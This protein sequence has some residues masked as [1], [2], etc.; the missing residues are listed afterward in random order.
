MTRPVEIL[1]LH[2]L[3]VLSLSAQE[4][5]LVMDS[6]EQRTIH[7]LA[8]Q[9]VE[10][11]LL[12]ALEQQRKAGYLEASLTLRPTTG[13]TLQVF[14]EQG[15][16]I[17]LSQVH[18]PR[19]TPRFE[20]YYRSELLLGQADIAFQDLMP[21]EQSLRDLGLTRLTS[22]EISRDAGG[23]YHL[24]YPESPQPELRIDAMAA[25]NQA[26]NTDTVAWYGNINLIVPNLGGSGKRIEL[27][28]KR[29]RSNSERFELYYRHPLLFARP[30]AAEIR[31]GREVVDG[32][33]Q[34]VTTTGGLNYGISWDQKVSLMYESQATLITRE[35]SELNANW[36]A[37]NHRSLG[38]GYYYEFRAGAV[39]SFAIRSSFWHELNFEPNSNS[40]LELRGEASRHLTGKLTLTQR[41]LAEVQSHTDPNDPGARLALGGEGSVRGY[42][43]GHVRSLSI[44]ALQ[45]DLEW[46]L[47][48]Q[49]RIF[50]VYD[51]GFY[52]EG[53]KIRQLTGYGLGIQLRSSS[54]PLRLV[55]ASHAGIGF[56]HSFIHIEYIGLRKWIDRS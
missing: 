40:R 10:A 19:M 1:L 35:G 45:H 33:Y 37:G 51:L 42:E 4:T 56:R 50:G 26:S 12:Q 39:N 44:M 18:F 7:K 31:F 38:L 28:W 16:Q 55:I 54:A 32:L 20:S 36:L 30:L 2:L 21:A 34:T 3:L 8:P 47:D 29:L 46:R 6:G 52:L 15:A 49:S 17:I 11:F 5:Y 25:F 41:T 27:F 43:E 14:L 24:A 48:S 13:D 9:E 53:D 23:Q 22:R